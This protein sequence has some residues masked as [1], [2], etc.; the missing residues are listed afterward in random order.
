M[1]EHVFNDVIVDGEELSQMYRY[2][3]NAQIFE[4]FYQGKNTGILLLIKNMKNVK[5][6]NDNM[7]NIEKLV[8]ERID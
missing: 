1:N 7:Y 5:K 4:F 2:A 8:A 3:R 6:I